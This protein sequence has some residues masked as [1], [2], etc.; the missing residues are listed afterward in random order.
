MG[1][2]DKI[3]EA[4]V[5]EGGVYILPGIYRCQILA[6]KQFETRKK[7]GAVA[8]EL[9]VLESSN[10]DRPIGS[11]MSWV[12]TMDKDAAMGNIKQFVAAAMAIKFEE[13]DPAGTEMIFSKDNPLKGQIIRVSA[14]NKPTQKGTDFTRVWWVNDAEGNAAVL[15]ANAAQSAG[16][17]PPQ[18]DAKT[19]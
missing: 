8:V 18:G 14:Y 4:K 7:I 13:V 16:K 3:Q 5:T 10:P 2:F 15:A 1:M 6:C 9:R 11:D 17:E 12:A 19:T